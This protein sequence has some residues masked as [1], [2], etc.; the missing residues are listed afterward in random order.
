MR[1]YLARMLAAL[2]LAAALTGC[3]GD[4]TPGR[5]TIDVRKNGRVVHT[6]VENFTESY[7]NLDELTDS[8]LQD[9]EAYNTAAGKQEVT[10]KSAQENDG[11]VTVVM[12]YESAAAYSGFNKLALFSGTVKDAFNAGYD[13]DVT[14]QSMKEDGESIGKDE[15]LGMG[16]KHIVVVREAADVRVWGKVRYATADASPTEDPRTVTVTDD[17]TLTYILFD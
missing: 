15:L 5:T 17:E 12:N 11:V 16:E 6:I 13:L 4:D 7:Y 1:K 9:C 2:L 10:M 3:S 14:L 8:I